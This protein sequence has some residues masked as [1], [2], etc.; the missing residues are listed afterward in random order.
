VLSLQA[1]LT[2][3]DE[4]ERTYA[5]IYQEFGRIDV[6]FNNAGRNDPADHSALDMT[7]QTWERVFAANLT[8]TFLSCK[9]GIPYLLRNDPPSGSVINTASFLAVMGAATSQ[10]AYSAAKAAVIQLSRD[11]GTH[12]AR[13]GVRVNA[14]CLG[15]IE[16]PQLRELFSRLPP[17]E[18]PKRLIHYPMGRFGPVEEL[19]G[20]VAYLASDDAGFVT[21]SAFPI[22]GGIT[23]AFTVPS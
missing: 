2:A 10:M 11:L 16:T 13:R 8:T 7:Q 5:R 15:P 1:D 18:L 17:E 19:A 23:A 3:E 21:A 4:V 20:T 22:D 12:L 6:L 9:H 14:L